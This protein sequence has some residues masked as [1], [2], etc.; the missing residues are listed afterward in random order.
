MTKKELT[1][2]A[3]SPNGERLLQTNANKSR[4]RGLFV[5]PVAYLF[6]IMTLLGLL[7]GWENYQ[8]ILSWRKY[9]PSFAKEA[10]NQLMDFYAW[11]LISL[12]IWQLMRVFSL[13]GPK[14]KRDLAAHLVISVAMAPFATLLYIAGIAATRLGTDTMTVMARLR[15]NLRS[16][17]I[18]NAIEYLTIVAI[19]VSVEYYRRYQHEEQEKLQLQH[20]LTESKLQTLRAQLNPHFL[21]N[22]MNSVS[23]LLHRDAAAADTMLSRVANLLRLTLARDNSREVRLLE[24]VELAEEY[25]EIQKIRFGPRLKLD[26]D[27]A[28][29]ALEALVPNMLL[30]PLVENACVH[31]IARTH[32]ECRL[33]IEARLEQGCLVLTIYNDGPPV[34]RDWKT[35]S[36]IGLRNTMERL[37]LLYDDDTKLELSNVQSGVRLRL[38][39]PVHAAPG[40]TAAYSSI[41]AT[42]P[43]QPSVM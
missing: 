13:Q 36:G 15:L 35:H 21:F 34:R 31:G 28:D 43:I 37:S 2:E 30:Q 7:M 40:G 5:I 3:I 27:I 38:R 25:L 19:I 42:T 8:L 23:C 32:G 11:G 1:A 4:G 33:T 16:E 12:L 6:G 41:S 14:W 17:V 24:E 10:A 39:I 20:A 26:I 29:D 22:A 9:N 18:P